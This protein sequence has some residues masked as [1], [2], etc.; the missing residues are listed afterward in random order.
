ML[1]FL[2]WT[3]YKACIHQHCWWALGWETETIVNHQGS[4]E[5]AWVSCPFTKMKACSLMH[6]GLIYLGPVSVGVGM[7]IQTPPPSALLTTIAHHWQWANNRKIW[8]PLKGL[9]GRQTFFQL[10]ILWHS[11]SRTM[12]PVCP[13]MSKFHK[14][15]SQSDSPG[16]E[17]GGL[18]YIKVPPVSW[19]SQFRN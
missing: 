17:L 10:K 8:L 16:V 7:L 1:A 15:M 13:Q 5:E 12:T 14:Y 3:I 6:D 4:R 9:D 19:H 11:T 2:P 18:P